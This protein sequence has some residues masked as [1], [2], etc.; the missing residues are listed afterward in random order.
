MALLA[1]HDSDAH[2]LFKSEPGSQC[3]STCWSTDSHD[4]EVKT[5]PTP[6]LRVMGS[7]SVEESLYKWLNAVSLVL[8]CICIVCLPKFSL[9][10][11]K[12]RE[13]LAQ[14]F[15]YSCYNRKKKRVSKVWR[16]TKEQSLPNPKS[17]L[18]LEWCNQYGWEMIT[19]GLGW[20]VWIT[21]SQAIPMCTP[22]V[23]LNF[24]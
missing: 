13:V 14:H 18:F 4:Q 8:A 6:V 11:R 17:G 19:F 15:S 12:E 22:C 24:V 5:T 9:R 23:N 1:P 7:K 21:V 3:E 16:G 10:K 2:S 20:G